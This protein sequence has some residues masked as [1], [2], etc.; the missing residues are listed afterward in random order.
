MG[1]DAQLDDLLANLGQQMGNL[2]NNAPRERGK[3][4]TCGKAITGELVEA[5]GRSYH[6]DHFVC[7]K[8]KK[9]LH[10]GDYYEPEGLPHCESCYHKHFLGG[11]QVCAKCNQ[12]ITSGRAVKAMDRSWHPHHFECAS[13]SSNLE[14]KEFFAQNNQPYCVQC[15]HSAFSRVC[16][17]CNRTIQGE[18]VEAQDQ[19]YHPACFVCSTSSCRKSLA[20]KSF[21]SHQGQIY[22]E[23]HY[24]SVASSFC[25]CGKAI[26]GQYASALGQKWH[27]A[28]FVCAYCKKSLVGGQFVEIENKAYC[29]ECDEKLF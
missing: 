17:A 2:K 26:Q 23:D 15:Y 6:T 1:D 4:F 18:Q 8:C 3:C 10:G 28:C 14:G 24:H 16:P 12:K 21:F 7:N 9:P 20:G 19:V 27:P 25:A 5:S 22:C 29:P 13:C 11:A